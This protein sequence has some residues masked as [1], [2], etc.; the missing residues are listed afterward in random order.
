V[1]RD[2]VLAS[3]GVPPD[4]SNEERLAGLATG[5][6]AV[7]L[8]DDQAALFVD[9]DIWRQR[10]A[11]VYNLVQAEQVAGRLPRGDLDV[12]C[13]HMMDAFADLIT[14]ERAVVLH[15][16]EHERLRRKHPDAGFG[17]VGSDRRNAV[18]Y[19]V[20][21]AVNLALVWLGKYGDGGDGGGGPDEPSRRLPDPNRW[22]VVA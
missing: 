12:T 2:E 21:G 6:L 10:H 8:F 7:D 19:A 1:S 4:A 20:Y 13:I 14:D 22:A 11:E 3:F 18:A 5:L 17:P 9:Q 16:R 15:E